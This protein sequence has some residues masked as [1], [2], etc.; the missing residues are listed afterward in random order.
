MEE[1]P[2][3]ACRREE[4]WEEKRRKDLRS[5]P[6]GSGKKNVS[7]SAGRATDGPPETKL[8]LHVNQVS[9]QEKFCVFP[10]KTNNGC[11]TRGF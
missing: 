3:T 4:A 11:R 2:D 1:R 9:V 7:S 8:F 6:L 10:A 5:I